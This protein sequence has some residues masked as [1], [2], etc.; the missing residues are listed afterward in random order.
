ME[1]GEIDRSGRRRPVPIEGSEF[2]LEIDTL[3]PAIGQRPDL[4][5]AETDERLKT[6]KSS[7]IEVDPETLCA[8]ADGIFA[9]GD[10]VSGPN[11][12]TAA[13]AH[14]KVAAKMIHKY[15]QAQP[16]EQEYKVTRPAIRVEAVEL[17]DKEIE[18]LQKPAVPVLDLQERKEGFKEVE[19]GFTEEMAIK[20]AKRCLRC[21]LE[22]KEQE[23]V[24]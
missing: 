9:G 20:E 2:T 7:T 12:V 3:M 10:A 19:L 16:M 14:G 21:D 24:V 6:T 15:I 5:V 4:I 11:A 8:G 23:V 13:M 18:E 22:L 1:L 17:T